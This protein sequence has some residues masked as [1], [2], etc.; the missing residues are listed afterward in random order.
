M[1]TQIILF[2]FIFVIKVLDKVPCK[3]AYADGALC[4]IMKMYVCATK[5]T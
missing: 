4:I 1:E 3:T 2:H 5:K